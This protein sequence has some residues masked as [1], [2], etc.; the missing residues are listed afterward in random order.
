MSEGKAEPLSEG[1]N[2]LVAPDKFKGT[3]SAGE[4][5]AAISEGVRA[6][7]AHAVQCP[8]ADGGEGTARA[9]V[10]ALGGEWVTAS[11]ADPL[12]R[13]V[14]APYGLIEGGR[15]AVIEVAAAS[16]YSLIAEDERDA[17][18][19]S[20]RGT[21]ELMSQAA[22]AGARRLVIA[23]GGSATSDGGA[24]LL[25]AFD[26][27][28]AGV[29]IDLLVDTRARFEECARIYSP[30][31]GASP[32]QIELIEKRL[33]TL[34]ERLPRDPRGVEGTGAAGG[35][36]GGLW[37]H[38]ARIVPGAGY[39][40]DVLGFDQRLAGAA[41][42]ITGEGRLD[43]SSLTGKAPIEIAS[44][45]RAA[46]VRCD[47]IVGQNTL[48][49]DQAADAGFATVTEAGTPPEISAGVRALLEDR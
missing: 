2:V 32:A 5:A 37:A 8:V 24:G 34:A 4:V 29:E 16:G 17:L 30:Q 43:E 45:A 23:C 6:A 7:G 19:A 42:V 48:S 3:M 35:I 26:P 13:R 36:S 1:W 14:E 12:G 28:A 33:A 27:E 21:G 20:S 47:A 40:L 11:A 41:F 39:V 22:A 15:T 31:K 25:G 9:L 44:R 49:A 18:A 46:G 38:G 10:E